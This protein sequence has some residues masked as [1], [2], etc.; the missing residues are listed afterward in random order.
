LP[1]NQQSDYKFNYGERDGSSRA[2][3]YTAGIPSCPCRIGEYRL[4]GARLSITSVHE[5]AGIN[6][7]AQAIAQLKAIIFQKAR[8]SQIHAGWMG[9]SEG[10]D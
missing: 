3:P 6:Y 9:F 7:N 2:R 5:A 10:D 4:V 8:L 1:E